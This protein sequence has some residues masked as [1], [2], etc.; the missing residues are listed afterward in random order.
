MSIQ[1]SAAALP[2]SEIT[3]LTRQQAVQRAD[4]LFDQFDLNRDGV[5]S[6][7]EAAS[8]GGRLMMQRAV[9]GRDV[10]PGI[11]GHT[12]K[13]LE[14]AFAGMKR[15]DRRQFERAMVTHFDQMDSNHDGL[16]SVAER[17]GATAQMTS[18]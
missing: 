15:V 8:A 3:P 12:L 17:T 6:R 14:H 13:F 1:A 11:G 18:R 4:A 2:A 10:A 16:L 7:D 5:I 9:T